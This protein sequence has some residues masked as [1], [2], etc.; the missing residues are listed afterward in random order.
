MRL[1]LPIIAATH[2]SSTY[3]QLALLW[4][5]RPLLVAETT[6]PDERIAAM[7]QSAQAAGWIKPGQTVAIASGTKVGTAGGTNSFRLQSV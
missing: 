7:V 4:G 3:R 1:A 2:R 5:V 6:N